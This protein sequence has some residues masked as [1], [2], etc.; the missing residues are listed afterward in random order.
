MLILQGAV[1]FSHTYCAHFPHPFI[2]PSILFSAVVGITEKAPLHC[3]N[4]TSSVNNEGRHQHELHL[5]M[6]MPFL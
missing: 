1:H 4:C 6:R 2:S 3:V 5:L